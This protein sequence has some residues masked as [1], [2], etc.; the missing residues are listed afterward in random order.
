M[1]FKIPA[2]LYKP[3]YQTKPVESMKPEAPALTRGGIG[4]W[5]PF[6]FRLSCCFDTAGEHYS[7]S[8]ASPEFWGSEA[9]AGVFRAGF[10]HLGSVDTLGHLVEVGRPV[11]GRK[12]KQHL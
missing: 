7:W 6:H 9:L 10:L 5:G 3:L 11:C 12:F 8:L 1:G 2:F 4:K